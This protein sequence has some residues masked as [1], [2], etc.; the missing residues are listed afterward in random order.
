MAKLEGWGY[1][2]YEEIKEYWF[3]QPVFFHDSPNSEQSV[4]S[5]VWLTSS[6]IWHVTFFCRKNQVA[7]QQKCVITWKNM[8]FWFSSAVAEQVS[9]VPWVEEW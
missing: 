3:H 6:G 5:Q 8:I 9:F 4:V 1:K 2:R 7:N